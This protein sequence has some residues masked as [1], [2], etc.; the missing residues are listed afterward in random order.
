MADDKQKDFTLEVNFS[1]LCFF[2]FDAQP[3]RTTIVLPDARVK[4]ENSIAHPDPTGPLVHLDGSD[5]RAHVGYLRFN[6]LNRASPSSDEAFGSA[7]DEPSYHVIHPFHREQITIEPLDAAP[8]D[9]DPSP[10]FPDISFE[11]LPRL[12]KF[13]VCLRPKPALLARTPDQ[14]VLA[15]LTLDA[16]Q[17]T[18]TESE[19]KWSIPCDLMPAGPADDPRKTPYS[20]HFGRDMVWRRRYTGKGI[21][22]TFAP[23]DGGKQQIVELTPIDADGRKIKLNIGNLC[24][25]NPF[26]M[27]EMRPLQTEY[28]EPDEDFKWFYQMLEANPKHQVS[29]PAPL[30]VPRP[31]SGQGGGREGDLQGCTKLHAFMELS[32]NPAESVE[33]ND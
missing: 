15:R 3:P 24:C 29:F 5:A 14:S 32:D 33:S 4:S 13:A 2:L 11:S 22:I 10:T 25:D 21:R 8:V 16:G 12:D 7:L 6:L 30:P 28:L 1:G 27:T 20:G 31:N 18:V 17:Y 9:D 23:F 26:D 19:L